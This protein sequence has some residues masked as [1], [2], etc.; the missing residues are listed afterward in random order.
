MTRSPAFIGAVISVPIVILAV[1][2]SPLFSPVEGQLTT[3]N[4]KIRGE[5]PAD[6][7][8]VVLTIDNDAI[9]T[10]GW[11]VRRN[12]QALM[13]HALAELRP[14]AIGVEILFEDQKIG[15]DEFSE[16]DTL[17]AAMTRQAGNVVLAAYF[18]AV[19]PGVSD[20]API[21]RAVPVYPRLHG[22]FPNGRG[23]HL[24]FPALLA[25][26]AGV[27]HVNFGG[28]DGSALPP[29]IATQE[30]T[31]PAFAL[32]VFRVATGTLRNDVWLKNDI[33]L[34]DREGRERHIPVSPSGNV[35]L[36]FPGPLNSYAHYSFLELLR[37]YDAARH[38]GKETVP[39]ESLQGRIIL[40]GIV[41]E[42]RSEFRSTPVGPRTPTIVIHAA[43]LDN[44][45]LNRFPLAVSRYWLILLMA[46]A[47][48]LSSYSILALRRPNNIVV[49]I[50]IPVVVLGASTGAFLLARIVLPVVGI[51]VSGVLA[52]IAALVVRWRSEG[53]Q[54]ETLSAEKEEI[55][56]RLHDRE[57]KVASL[58]RELI[59][60]QQQP[61]KTRSEELLEEIRRYKAEIHDLTTQAN[62]M[63]E[64]EAVPEGKEHLEN[65]EG[66][67]YSSSGV[68]KPAVDFVKKI[69]S[70]DAPV[71]ILGESGTGKEL[72]AR[73]I[74]ARS[75]RT[76]G[77]FVAVNCGALAEGLLE[78]ELFG[79][80]KGAFTGAV[81]ERMGRFELADKGTIFLD[82]IGEVSEAF[83]LKL[84]RV[85]QEGEFERVGGTKT[86]KV[87]VRVLAATNKDLREEVGRKQFRED[88]YYRINVLTI[89]LPPLRDR[90]TDIEILVRHFL[91]RENEPI[92]VSKGVMEILQSHTWP[93]NVR[94]LES[95][96]RRAVLL[97]RADGRA[98]IV[99]RDLPDTLAAALRGTVPVQDR[100]LELVRLRGFSRS[101]VSDAAVEL[102][103]L[104]RGTVAE[105][106]RGECLK[107]FVE[108]DFDKEGTI[109]HIALSNDEQMLGR[110]RKRLEE[111]LVNITPAVDRSQP[112]EKSLATLK[113]KMKNLPQRYH[114]FV[115]KA[116][117]A[118]YRG[119]WK[120]DEEPN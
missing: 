34:L 29:V 99:A 73:A 15:Y 47:T 92:A 17:L 55:L 26:A 54:V 48:W 56:T 106:L 10:L 25:S 97:A 37:S 27:G 86:T 61:T 120:L 7:D 67:I 115:E 80:E 49:A 8:I 42:G 100:V 85:L 38:G 2:L 64:F 83:Q 74:H 66:I 72:V 79:H 107:I 43:F 11:P 5:I 35:P 21:A 119:R 82:E 96:V 98:M 16:Y 105:Y 87:D 20:T 84:L 41:A 68:M 51:V 69:A 63:E 116:G 24:P 71:L 3:M 78:S 101:A 114:E 112:W 108:D 23:L 91:A 77:A 90:S 62:D 93:G 6:S 89:A 40:V 104:N 109:R 12:F 111:Y 58:E 53:K 36:Y 94:E 52:S 60:K 45:L 113:P 46:G 81:R 31:V 19:G 32:D 33:I 57:A 1:F 13:I 59:S 4:Y 117:E 14:K 28:D 75:H 39:V 70:S 95:T 102:G 110:V 118:Y 50:L 103:G 22:A 65:F 30:G 44:A 9:K 18:E 76:G 88:L